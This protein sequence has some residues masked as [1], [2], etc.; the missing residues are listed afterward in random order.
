[1]ANQF[2]TAF[3]ACTH[4]VDIF[5]KAAQC[6]QAHT[7]QDHFA[8]TVDTGHRATFRDAILNH[9]PGNAAAP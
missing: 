9:T 1:M 3:K 4:F 7:L 2:D 5:R 6:L 8:T